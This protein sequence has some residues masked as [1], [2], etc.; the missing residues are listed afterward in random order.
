MH[1]NLE[2]AMLPEEVRGA[3]EA[4]RR[5]YGDEAFKKD[6]VTPTP[7]SKPK[8]PIAPVAPPEPYIEPEIER[9]M[10]GDQVRELR[11]QLEEEA[12]DQ[13]DPETQT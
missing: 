4:Y 7:P 1:E 11:R 12:R 3:R 9:T 10:H 8:P 2:D 6:E 13:R 5:V